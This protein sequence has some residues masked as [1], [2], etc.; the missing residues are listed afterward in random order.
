MRPF[1][2]LG[3]ALALTLAGCSQATPPAPAASTPPSVAADYEDLDARTLELPCHGRSNP[4]LATWSCISTDEAKGTA[5]INF[6]VR[7]GATVKLSLVS[8]K[9]PTPQWDPDLVE[10]Q[11]RFDYK[12]ATYSAG[13]HSITIKIPDCFYQVDFVVG[14]SIEHLTRAND[15]RVETGLLADKWGGTRSC[16]TYPGGAE[17]CTPGY[18][19]NHPGAWAGTGLTASTTLSAAFGIDSNTSLIT[20]LKTGGGGL[21]ALMRHAVAALL[22]ASSTGVAYKFTAAEV[23]ALVQAA[24]TSKNYEAAKNTLAKQNEMGCPLN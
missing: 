10:Q 7:A 23:R 20:A 14:D 15:Y 13:S 4:D 6:T 11:V 5:T 16:F 17:G 18:W 2:I 24:V 19:K 8:Y 9:A 21:N 3:T 1:T 22:N 12:T